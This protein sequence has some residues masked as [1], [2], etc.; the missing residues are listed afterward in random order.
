MHYKKLSD[1]ALS[2]IN[3]FVANRK[4]SKMKSKKKALLFSFQNKK[5][6]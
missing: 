1:T 3:K 5:T 6:K 2:R 4:T